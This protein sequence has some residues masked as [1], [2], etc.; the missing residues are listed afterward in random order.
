MFKNRND[1]G[2][3][4]AEK[5]LRFKD[6]EVVLLAIPRGGLPLGAIVAQTLGAPLDVVLSK[7]IGHP[8]NKE[9]AIGALSLNN[10]ILTGAMGVTK[11]YIKKETIAIR[12]KLKERHQQYYKNKSPQN[13]KNKTVI[14]IDDGIATGNTISITVEL[15]HQQGAKKI[16]VAIPV[17]PK[18]TL[19]KLRNSK[20]IDEV[21]CLKTPY[22]FKA[23]GQFYREFPQVSD[24]KAIGLLEKAAQ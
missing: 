6:Q 20:Y 2:R 19:Q 5:L 10:T 4:L 24:K 7:K 3:Q 15:V 18:S 22:N 13:L 8:Y 16:I 11:G 21:I 14:I 9:Y 17:A 23:V 12:Q 1:A